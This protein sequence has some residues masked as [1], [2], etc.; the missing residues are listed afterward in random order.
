MNY[1]NCPNCKTDN[2]PNGGTKTGWLDISTA[3]KNKRVLIC[4]G[5]LGVIIGIL[6]T[7]SFGGEKWADDSMEPVEI[8]LSPTHW[9]PLPEGAIA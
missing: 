2:Y 1:C 8:S 9:M 5:K 7:I 4:F 3:P 6:D